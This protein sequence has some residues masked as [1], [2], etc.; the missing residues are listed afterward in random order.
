MRIAIGLAVLALW[1]GGGA[2]AALAADGTVTTLHGKAFL[3]HDGVT[4][5]LKVN[6]PVSLGDTI[7]TKDGARAQIVFADG[8]DIT[9]GENGSLSIDD[10]VYD[11]EGAALKKARFSILH[12]A[13]VY[14]SGAHDKKAQPDAAVRVDFGSIGIRGTKLYRG[15]RDGQC[16]IYL[17]EGNISVANK[18]GVVNLQPGDLTRM[19]SQKTA[20]TKPVKWD[21]ADLDWI[22]AETGAK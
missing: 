6:A 19:S 13:F 3:T 14:L 22:K 4:A 9:I 1:L 18:S 5:P 11:P 7:E 2:Q 16:W 20:P 15:M 12:T 8:T 21:P 10:F 17:E